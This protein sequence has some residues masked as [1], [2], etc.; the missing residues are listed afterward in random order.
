MARPSRSHALLAILVG[1][2][3][4][5][6]ACSDSD[7][8]TAGTVT[9]TQVPATSTDVDPDGGATTTVVATTTLASTTTVPPTTAAPTTAPPATT[10]APEPRPD[11]L[12]LLGDG[13]G[14]LAFGAPPASAIEFLSAALGTPMADSGWTDSFSVYGTCPGSEVRGVEWPGF[15][16]LFGDADDDYSDGGQHFMSWAVGWFGPDPFGMQTPEG[17]GIGDSRDTI[18]GLYLSATFHPAEASFPPSVVIPTD[19]GD[20]HGTFEDGQALSYLTAGT[21]CGD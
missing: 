2:A 17:V 10:E 4:L 13:L 12:V 5:I 3:A 16:A 14:P 11:G 15:L 20:L 9:T 19:R 8:D 6:A 18:A 7:T 1:I 21:R